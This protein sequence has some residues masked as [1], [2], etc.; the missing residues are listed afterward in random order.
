VN[1]LDSFLY[2]LY[3]G[4]AGGGGHARRRVGSGGQ[5]GSQSRGS[6][7]GVTVAVRVR[8]L[9]P[10]DVEMGAANIIVSM[11]GNRSVQCK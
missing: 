6:K 8:P 5:G 3:D 10:R 1:Q 9:S 11:Q 2:R 7:C 4:G